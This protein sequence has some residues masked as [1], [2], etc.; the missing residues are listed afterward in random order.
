[1]NGETAAAAMY[2]GRLVKDQKAGK[3][4]DETIKKM[5][6]LIEDYNEKSKPAFCAKMGFVDEIVKMPALRNYVLA[7]TDAAYQNPEKICPIHQMLLP[8]II[9]DEK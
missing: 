2:T 3:P 8:R 5:N 4:L 7:F 6:A 9:R 1:M